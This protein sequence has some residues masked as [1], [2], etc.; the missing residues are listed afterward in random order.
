MYNDVSMAAGLGLTPEELQDLKSK[1]NDSFWIFRVIGYPPLP[2]DH[3]G[4]SCGAHK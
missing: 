4:I 1:T 2:P 3:D